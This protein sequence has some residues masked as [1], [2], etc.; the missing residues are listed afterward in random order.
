MVQSTTIIHSNDATVGVTNGTEFE[1]TT[2]P[3]ED[4]TFNRERIVLKLENA[5]STLEDHHTNWSTY[6]NAQKLQV[7]RHLLKSVIWLI[8]I[9][10]RLL[11][12]EG[13]SS[14]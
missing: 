11:Q 7:V 10:Q 9:Q 1:R 14:S 3:I 12:S 5:L 13:P 4:E 2:S 8:R 6:D